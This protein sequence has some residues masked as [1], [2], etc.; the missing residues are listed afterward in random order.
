MPA[1]ATLGR[2]GGYCIRDGLNGRP[3]AEVAISPRM[4]YNSRDYPIDRTAS[5]GG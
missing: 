1:G 3:E 4:C 5:K 2:A